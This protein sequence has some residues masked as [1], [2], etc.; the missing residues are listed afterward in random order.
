MRPA[1][2][3]RLPGVTAL[4]GRW[5]IVVAALFLLTAPLYAD[6]TPKISLE[7]IAAA[8]RHSHTF[9]PGAE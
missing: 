9:I 8:T 6:R 1:T 7:E 3:S 4:G 5:G 2:R